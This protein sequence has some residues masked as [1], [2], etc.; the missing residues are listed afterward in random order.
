MFEL[1]N[2]YDK[3]SL[4]TV[5]TLQEKEIIEHFTAQFNNSETFKVMSLN[6]TD[7][8]VE[9]ENGLIEFTISKVSED[10]EEN[11]QVQLSPYQRERMEKGAELAKLIANNL[12]TFNYT[13]FI[14]AF[15]LAMSREHRTLQQSFT[16]FCFEWIKFAGSDEYQTDGRNETSKEFCQKITKF[17]EDNGI[18]R[19]P[20]I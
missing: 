2:K 1:F 20:L 7:G 8:C 12:N 9:G 14:E 6:N 4:G 13:E 11:E 19:L 18:I 17:M 10:E 3:S 5:N 15:T 16:Q